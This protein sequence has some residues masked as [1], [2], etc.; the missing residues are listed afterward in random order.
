MEDF[1]VSWVVDKGLKARSMNLSIQPFTLIGATTRFGMVSAP[2][3]D[4]FGSIH[5]LEFYDDEAM[6]TIVS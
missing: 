3:R 5:R 2:L 6:S 4:R 1:F